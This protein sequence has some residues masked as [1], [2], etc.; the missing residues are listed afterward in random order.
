MKFH[1]TDLI[2]SLYWIERNFTSRGWK[3]WAWGSPNIQAIPSKKNRRQPSQSNWLFPP[4]Q[5][6]VINLVFVYWQITR[7]WISALTSSGPVS[8]RLELC[9]VGAIFQRFSVLKIRLN[10]CPKENLFPRRRFR[11]FL[12]LLAYVQKCFISGLSLLSTASENE[13]QCF[14]KD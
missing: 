8:Q 6:D 2:C 3:G 11:R 9:R 12:D 7:G 4:S 10:D 1:S 13:L 14:T 5:T